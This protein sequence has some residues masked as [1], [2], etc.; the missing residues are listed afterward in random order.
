MIIDEHAAYLKCIDT[1]FKNTDHGRLERFNLFCYVSKVKNVIYSLV[2]G[3]FQAEMYWIV[4]TS[5]VEIIKIHIIQMKYFH[6]NNSLKTCKN[7]HSRF[8]TILNIF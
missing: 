5:G 8:M 3:C 6:Q 4:Q 7:L 1:I 2:L